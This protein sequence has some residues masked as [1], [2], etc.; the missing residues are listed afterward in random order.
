MCQEKM[1]LGYYTATTFMHS[2]QL[3]QST[4]NQAFQHLIIVVGEAHEV[5]YL[6]ERFLTTNGCRGVYH[7][8]KWYDC[9]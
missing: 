9:S 2:M 6:Q 3:W 8:L 7:F 5:P 4:Q 1:S